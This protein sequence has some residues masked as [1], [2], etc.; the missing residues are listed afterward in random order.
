MLLFH[1]STLNLISKQYLGL[2]ES[3]WVDFKFPAYNYFLFLIKKSFLA[4]TVSFINIFVANFRVVITSE[5][6]ELDQ[7]CT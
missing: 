3:R 6:G 1:H 2:R 4:C 7:T 5:E